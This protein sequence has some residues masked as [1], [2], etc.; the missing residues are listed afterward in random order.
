MFYRGTKLVFTASKNRVSIAS[1]RNMARL[2]E[3][4]ALN[5]NTVRLVIIRSLHILLFF[6]IDVNLT[7]IFLCF[8]D[9]SH[10]NYN[11]LVTN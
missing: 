2:L 9:F 4:Q 11:V 1:L 8:N 3:L 10:E 7:L 6:R 5:T